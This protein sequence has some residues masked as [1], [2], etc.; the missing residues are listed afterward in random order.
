MIA[1]ESDESKEFSAFSTLQ[2][3]EKMG[4]NIRDRQLREAVKKYPKNVSAAISALEEAI[5]EKRADR[6][7]Q[8]LTAG[9]RERWEP[10]QNKAKD[11]YLAEFNAWFDWANASNLVLASQRA[12]DGSIKIYARNDRWY[13]FEEL[14][15][16]SPE[17]LAI[18]VSPEVA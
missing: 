18:K 14:R 15:Y 3:V 1:T 10:K 4:V 17:E 13:S 2:I 12:D 6:P 9:I 16:L 8:Y 11:D 7:T 5:R